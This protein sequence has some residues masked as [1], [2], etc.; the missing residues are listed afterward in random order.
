M[1]PVRSPL[2]RR[3]RRPRHPVDVSPARL[4]PRRPGGPGGVLAYFSV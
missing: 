4:A 1:T 2:R 3:R